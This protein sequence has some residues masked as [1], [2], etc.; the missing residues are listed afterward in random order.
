M[1]KMI[2]F[3]VAGVLSI[4]MGTAVFASASYNGE[5]QQTT[6]T[7]V[8]QTSYTT[9]PAHDKSGSCT[10]MHEEHNE[11][12]YNDKTECV[13]GSSHGITQGNRH[14]NTHHG[15]NGVSQN[16]GSGTHHY[17]LH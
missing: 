1:K 6:E 11:H 13:H 17:E 8:N 3:G 5:M 9:V 4:T 14:N 7:N 10:F 16:A 2:M 12:C 15:S